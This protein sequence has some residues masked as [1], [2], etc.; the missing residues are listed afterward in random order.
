MSRL[1]N[2]YF[3]QKGYNMKVLKVVVVTA[4]IVAGLATL[5]IS[6]SADAATRTAVSKNDK[7][8]TFTITD[9][10]CIFYKDIPAGAPLRAASAYD[11]GTNA[12]II[13]CALD[14]GSQIEFQLV[15]EKESK[16]Y[17]FV[18]PTADFSDVKE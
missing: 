2:R 13:G 18:L 9:S 17:Q 11:A 12:T 16:H 4:S 5:S 14:Y 7:N 8:V 10:D 1:M 3:N 6:L 15:N